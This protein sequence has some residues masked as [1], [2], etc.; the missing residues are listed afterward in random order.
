ME[1]SKKYQQYS[2]WYASWKGKQDISSTS[3]AWLLRQEPICW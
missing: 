1:E 3:D 2:R